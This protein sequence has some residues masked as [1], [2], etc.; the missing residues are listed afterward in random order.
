MLYL[1]M[2]DTTVLIFS[3]NVVDC[4]IL[5]DRVLVLTY[6][7]LDKNVITVVIMTRITKRTLYFVHGGR[8]RHA[9]WRW[10]GVVH[11]NQTHHTRGYDITSL[12][13]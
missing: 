8:V 7:K 13:R 4:Q 9:Y 2:N 10:I 3:S 1:D 11:I 12:P 5:V 6:P